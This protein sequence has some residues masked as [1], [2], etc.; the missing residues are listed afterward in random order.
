MATMLHEFDIVWDTPVGDF[1]QMLDN[2]GLI[3]HK[4]VA[5]GP[6][7]GNPCITVEGTYKQI[8]NFTK[9]YDNE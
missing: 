3:L 5:Q 1:L 9:W 6:G 8:N 4:Y 7:G 2:H